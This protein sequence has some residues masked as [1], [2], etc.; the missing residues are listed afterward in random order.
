MIVNTLFKGYRDGIGDVAY[1]ASHN[2]RRKSE[3]YKLED[4]FFNPLFII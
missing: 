4:S 1:L 2:K 3:I